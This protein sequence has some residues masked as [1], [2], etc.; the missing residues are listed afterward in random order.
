[1]RHLLGI[2]LF[3]NGNFIAAANEFNQVLELSPRDHEALFYLGQIAR[4]QGDDNNALDCFLAVLEINPEHFESAFNI[5]NIYRDKRCLAKALSWFERALKIKPDHLQALMNRGTVQVLLG[6]QEKGI[7]D[8][9]DCLKINP[10]FMD[11]Y[12][13]LSTAYLHLRDFVAAEK[14][15][16]SAIQQNPDFVD[17]VFAKFGLL[18]LQQRYEE[19]LPLGEAR[20]D[21]RIRFEPKSLSIIQSRL[22]MDEPKSEMA[23]LST[24]SR[25][26]AIQSCSCDF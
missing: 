13:N 22:G 14:I 26:L 5:G 2:A 21:P 10:Y 17:A 16:D 9:E 4:T 7:K 20:L 24:L 12:Q 1:M 3:Q 19:A 8:F 15:L 23:C 11:A 25:A 18:A 6:H